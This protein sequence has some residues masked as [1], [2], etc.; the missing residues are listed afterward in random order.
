VGKLFVRNWHRSIQSN[1]IVVLLENE[2]ARA[3]PLAASV[4]NWL[5]TISSPSI[6]GAS[7]SLSARLRSFTHR[8]WQFWRREGSELAMVPNALAWAKRISERRRNRF[9]GRGPPQARKN[10]C[11][12]SGADIE[13]CNLVL[14]VG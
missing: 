11:H 14:S 3:D 1:G 8:R 6:G 7:G 12:E 5:P 4:S 2:S 10:L 13:L 9:H